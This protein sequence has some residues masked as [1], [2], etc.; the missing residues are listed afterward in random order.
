MQ[1][2][3]FVP[4]LFALS[5]IG[6]VAFAERAGGGGSTHAVHEHAAHE[7]TARPQVDRA[8]NLRAHGDVLEK[9]RGSSS[10]HAGRTTGAP[11]NRSAPSR[12]ACE[13]GSAGCGKE[14]H[15]TRESHFGSSR[16]ASAPSAA[17][18]QHAARL[19][20]M[21]QAKMCQKAHCGEQ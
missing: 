17:D 16:Q 4:V 3:L 9:T 18:Q 19:I 1:A 6:G 14:A 20:Q 15:S 7:H 13:P 10:S 5:S 21:L 11:S 2:R 8:E 12:T